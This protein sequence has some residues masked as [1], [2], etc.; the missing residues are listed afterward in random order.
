MSTKKDAIWDPR[1]APSYTPLEMLEMGVFEGKYINAIKG[2]PA[3]WYKLPKVLGPNDEPDETINYYGVKS[4][5]GLSEW[6][7]NGW[8]KTDKS[9]WF[10]W[11]CLYFLGRRLGDE[12][13]WQINRWRSFVARHSAQVVSKCKVGDKSCNTRQRQGLLQWAWNSDTKFT[14]EQCEKNLKRLQK[15]GEITL[16]SESPRLSLNW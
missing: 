4:R 15:R 8:I 13:T 2:L 14:D 7:K 12:D 6:K 5:Q 10:E 11:Y 16:Q 9:G 3:S 1:F